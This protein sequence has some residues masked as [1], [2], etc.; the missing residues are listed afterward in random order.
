M[1]APEL[2]WMV[3]QLMPALSICVTTYNRANWIATSLETILNQS[4]SD[5]EL[6]VVDNASTDN[7]QDVVHSIRDPR[8]RYVRNAVNCGLVPNQNRAIAEASGDLIAIYHD[9]DFYHPDIV[10]RSVEILN[11][12]P[13]VGMVCSAIY[14]LEPDF[15]EQ[16]RS[17][18]RMPLAPIT[19]GHIV[20]RELL[21]RWDC[22]I[23]APTAMVR[24]KC[25]E[26]AGVFKPE[27]A[28]G[29][30]RELWLRILRNW[31]LAYISE[32]MARLRGKNKLTRFNS[33]QAEQHWLNLKGHVEIQKTHLE[34]DFK[35]AP[36][37][38]V[39][40]RQRLKAKR[41]REFWRWGIWAVA[42]GNN[43]EFVRAGVDCFRE[44][45]MFKSASLLTRLH[46]SGVAQS[47]F[48][49]AI[50]LYKQVAA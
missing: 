9:D 49:G 14:V 26:D 33:A 22:R 24:R 34:E 15:P 28:G 40:E 19:P 6:I 23:P 46:R 25:Y 8:L 27:F 18:D 38:L 29:A 3:S 48:A 10:K 42:K 39:F 4:Y 31:D 5:F 41:F 37:S 1:S 45:G 30:D 17:L 21:H 36:L 12:H 13:N 11:N 16:V 2:L 35:N 32:P 44:S 50:Q 7:T 47:V 43:D 20:R